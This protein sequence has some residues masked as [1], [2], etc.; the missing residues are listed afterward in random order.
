MSQIRD[1][2]CFYSLIEQIRSLQTLWI[3]IAFKPPKLSTLKACFDNLILGSFALNFLSFGWVTWWNLFSLQTIT[4]QSCFSLWGIMTTSW[5]DLN[6]R[7]FFLCISLLRL[8]CWKIL[9]PNSCQLTSITFTFNGLDALIFFFWCIDFCLTWNHG[10]KKK[11][12]LKLGS[13]FIVVYKSCTHSWVGFVFRTKIRQ[14]NFCLFHI[15]LK[16]ITV[17]PRTLCVIDTK[18]HFWIFEWIGRS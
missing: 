18:M 16:K 7:T 4:R 10:E 3:M 6:K 9:Y 5:N 15:F 8:Q 13:E 14:G 12:H 11:F 17:L 2:S 1:L